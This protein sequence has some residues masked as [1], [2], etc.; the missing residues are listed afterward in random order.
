MLS[1]SRVCAPF[2]AIGLILGSYDRAP[3]QSSFQPKI[4]EGLA[5]AKSQMDEATHFGCRMA[6][7]FMNERLQSARD[8][9]SLEPVV[10]PV[11]KFSCDRSD[12]TK[13]GFYNVQ[14]RMMVNNKSASMRFE[15]AEWAGDAGIPET[16]QPEWLLAR[17][18]VDGREVHRRPG[19]SP[20]DE[21]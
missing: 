7:Y 19:Y 6:A 9:N 17:L 4:E 3:A 16:G 14:I 15:F 21:K 2:L 10:V 13:D 11:E 8:P 1:L 18:V 20:I 12:L 5:E